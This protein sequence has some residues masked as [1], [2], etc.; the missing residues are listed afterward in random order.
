MQKSVAALAILLCVC[1][2]GDASGTQP[3]PASDQPDGISLFLLGDSTSAAIIRDALRARCN[4]SPD[5]RWGALLMCSMQGLVIVHA[6][7]GRFPGIGCLMDDKYSSLGP[8]S[9][10]PHLP[11]EYLPS[12][13]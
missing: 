4:G 12:A 10:P 5:P 3:S 9:L 8:S 13:S 1:P 2:V 11:S 7:V 6:G